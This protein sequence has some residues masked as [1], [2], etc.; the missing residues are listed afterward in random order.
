MAISRR[1]RVE[2]TAA[3]AAIAAIG[4][5]GCSGEP[6]APQTE[7]PS[8]ARGGLQEDLGA[9][10]RAKDDHAAQ[11]LKIT[12]VVGAAVGRDNDGRA[13]VVILTTG[14][15]V[16]SLPAS[17]NGIPVVVQVTGTLVALPLQAAPLRSAR[18][19]SG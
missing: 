16:G 12:G 8:V 7:H 17:L 18:K 13:A 10:I 9:A 3:A 19:R 6:T 15:G 5:L 14:P 11:L 2:I 4:W 1:L